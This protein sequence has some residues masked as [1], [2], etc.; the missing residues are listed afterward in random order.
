MTAR[1]TIFARA[2]DPAYQPGVHHAYLAGLIADKLA[3]GGA[4][5]IVN[6]PP[7]HGKSRLFAVETPLCTHNEIFGSLQTS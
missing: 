5:L 4:R 6:M 3:R 7:R 1:P 2:C